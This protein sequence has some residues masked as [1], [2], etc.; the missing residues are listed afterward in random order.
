MF[1]EEFDDEDGNVFVAAA[2][3]VT[4]TAAADPVRATPSDQLHA[5]HG[6]VKAPASYGLIKSQRPAGVP[7]PVPAKT[8]P[9]NSTAAA[10]AAKLIKDFS[11]DQRGGKD[12]G[13]A[14]KRGLASS[15]GRAVCVEQGVI[16]IDGVTMMIT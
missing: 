15:A 10:A 13:Q 9:T 4:V 1:L 14:K 7:A 6:G 3:P 16:I 2:P 8:F 11:S 5:L 12:G